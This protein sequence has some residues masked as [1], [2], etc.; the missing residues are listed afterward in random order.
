MPDAPLLKV[1]NL[2]VSFGENEVVH[3]V[4][5][6]LQQGEILAIVG[7]SGSG[8]S[9]TCSAI[10]GLLPRGGHIT[11]GRCIHG[12]T[13]AHWAA[14][15]T[16]ANA[17]LGRGLSLVFQDPM[18][19]LNPSMRVGWQVAETAMVHRQCSTSEA[20]SLATALLKEVELPDPEAAFDKYPHEMS[21][22]QK[23]RVMIALAL[24]ADPEVLI[25]DEP[26]TALDATV[27]KSILALLKKVQGQR[28]MGVIFITHDLDVVH[29]IA[30]RV[31]VMQ[32]GRIVESGEVNTVL[33]QP[34]HPYTQALLRARDIDRFEQNAPSGSPL[35]QAVKASK[36]YGDFC[37]VHDVNLVIERGE[38]VGLIGESGSGKSTLG[39]MLIGMLP[40]TSGTITFDGEAVDPANRASMARLRGRAQLVFQDPYSA[41][42]PKLTVGSA[43]EEVL[44]HAGVKASEATHQARRLLEEVG[45]DASD[46]TKYPGGFSGGQR[47][48]I[49]I[50]RAL[51]MEPEFVVL[52]ESVAALDVQIQ[53]DV[54]ELLDRIGRE[55][56][57]T[58]LFISHDLDVVAS[59]CNRLVI[60]EKGRIVEA[61]ETDEILQHPATEYTVELLGSRPKNL[62]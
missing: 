22:G 12:P 37:A 50:A 4:N 7:E 27:Q 3:A 46:A 33:E 17:P 43:L 47:Q 35:V 44:I 62:R 13:G 31:L 19:S 58:Y 18:S 39:R 42:N 21:G 23:Q 29:A 1:E 52:D 30:D 5:F 2:T 20:R 26:T 8:K 45:L 53:R 56:Q 34:A 24:A 32:H 28:Q 49:V 55:R 38:R 61:G 51:A 60:L 59:F 11:H 25:A 40:A 36:W 6:D 15:E 9:V 48:R 57:L 54:L 10:A 16:P 14:A 41:L